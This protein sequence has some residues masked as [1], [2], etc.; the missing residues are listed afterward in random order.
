M[1]DSLFRKT[2]QILAVQASSEAAFLVVDPSRAVFQIWTNAAAAVT[3]SVKMFHAQS[4]SEAEMILLEA[5]C[6]HLSV[7]QALPDGHGLDFIANV[8]TVEPS[9]KFFYLG[10]TNIDAAEL[11]RLG[12]LAVLPPP[13]PGSIAE[14]L[15]ARYFSTPRHQPGLSGSLHVMPILDLVQLKC[16]QG[17][18][19][20]LKIRTPHDE[21][22]LY[23]SSTGLIHAST[24]H[25]SGQEAFDEVARWQDGTFEELNPRFQVNQTITVPWNTLLLNAARR[26]DEERASIGRPQ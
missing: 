15:L 2:G 12:I 8:K 17:R 5:P 16:L 9:A 24:R 25:L 10:Q 11:E 26:Q 21:A 20:H 19:G 6:Y 3:P 13:L 4:C 18:P 7:N 22:N 23:F 1:T 14:A